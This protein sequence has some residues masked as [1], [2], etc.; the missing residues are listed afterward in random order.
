LLSH[1]LKN[2]ATNFDSWV[3]LKQTF[4]AWFI[5]YS[6]RRAIPNLYE[7]NLHFC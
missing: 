6:L 2:E 1:L 7:T 4:D 5:I 3:K